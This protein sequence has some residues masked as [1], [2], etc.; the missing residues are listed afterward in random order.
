MRGRCQLAALRRFPSC[1]VG[2]AKPPPTLQEGSSEQIAC[3][4]PTPL[5]Q[6]KKRSYFLSGIVGPALGAGCLGAVG[7]GAAAAAFFVA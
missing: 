7:A 6:G 2:Y 1:R 3:S 4:P 5:P